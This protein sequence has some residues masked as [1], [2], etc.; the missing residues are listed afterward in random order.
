MLRPIENRLAP[1]AKIADFADPV[2]RISLSLIFII[3]GLGH[4]LAHDHMR[5]RMDLSPWKS[6]V[7]QIGDASILLWLSGAVFIIA[8][9]TL[10]LGWMTRL[11]AIALIVTLVPITIAV[12][13]AP[14]HTGP[15][16]KNVAIFGALFFVYARGA[17]KYAI[18][19]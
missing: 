16:F 8:G 12:H 7:E 10:A 3:G 4:F 17:G 6:I 14:G 13:I 2:L 15:L 11:S 9:V 18:D 5:G 1:S 19:D